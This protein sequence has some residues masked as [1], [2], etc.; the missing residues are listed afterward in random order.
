MFGAAVSAKE[1][2]EKL[3]LKA[4]ILS[5]RR[6]GAETE[7]RITPS[8]LTPATKRA[9]ASEERTLRRTICAVQLNEPEPNA[10][11]HSASHRQINTCQ[12]AAQHT[13]LR[14]EQIRADTAH[15]T[16]TVGCRAFIDVLIAG[17]AVKTLRSP[18][19]RSTRQHSSEWSE[20]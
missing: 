1:K 3:A 12:F 4:E 16:S 14:T 9:P 6:S 17:R 15:S 8:P 18:P 10:R 19:Q 13:T 20:L 7:A 5:S 11:R 2:V